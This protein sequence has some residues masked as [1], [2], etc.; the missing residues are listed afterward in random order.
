VILRQNARPVVGAVAGD[1]RV[2]LGVAF[3]DVD[4]RHLRRRRRRALQ[5]SGQGAMEAAVGG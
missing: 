5:L 4:L 3:Y 2:L 1:H